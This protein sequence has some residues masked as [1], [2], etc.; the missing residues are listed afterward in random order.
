[1]NLRSLLEKYN[2][3]EEVQVIIQRSPKGGF[4]AKLADYP[5]CF[6]VAETPYELLQNITDAILTYFEVP[7]KEAL[8]LNII[9]SPPLPKLSELEELIK[10]RRVPRLEYLQTP[11]F[12]FAALKN[13]Y[14]GYSSIR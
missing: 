9:Y 13:I 8:R 7:R 3:P 4:Y 1:M 12:Y 6:T 14:G 10:S 2:L 11:F 5:G